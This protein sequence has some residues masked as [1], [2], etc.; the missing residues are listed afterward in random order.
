MSEASA[1]SPVHHS[2]QVDVLRAIVRRAW[3]WL[4]ILI[5]SSAITTGA[6]FALVI[7]TWV[8]ANTPVYAADLLGRIL[9]FHG[10]LHLVLVVGLI[11]QLRRFRQANAELQVVEDVLAHGLPQNS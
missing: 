7:L 10:L 2:V 4:I 8:T 5:S 11:W 3:W 6:G 1:S 9:I